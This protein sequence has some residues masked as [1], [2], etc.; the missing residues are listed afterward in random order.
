MHR[1]VMALA[2]IVVSIMSSPAL[3]VGSVSAGKAKSKICI[4]CH[5]VDG[6]STNPVWPKLAGQ[7][8]IY[9]AKA[10]RDFR[11]GAR[12]DSVMSAMAK[13]L[14][15]DDIANLAAYYAAQTPK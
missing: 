13:P 3:A 11:S 4:S 8:S 12:K 2:T 14:S 10:L 15:D 7:H 6:N 1:R 5:G 9:L